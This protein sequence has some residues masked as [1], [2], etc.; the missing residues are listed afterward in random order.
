[1]LP[2]MTARA[3]AV[4]LAAGS[5]SRLGTDLPKAFLAIGGRSMLSIAA[6]AAASS[7]AITGLVITVPAGEESRAAGHLRELVVPASVIRGGATRQASVRAAL[8]V[9][10][11]DVE[12]VVVHDAAR[13]F[14]APS[15]FTAV[16]EAVVGGAI[17]AV[18]VVPVAD[19]VKRVRDE[20]VVETIDRGELALAQTPQ[21]FRVDALRAAH[22]RALSTGLEGTDDAMLLEGEAAVVAVPG[23]PSNFKVTTMFDLARAEAQ[24]ERGS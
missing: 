17:G 11:P 8:D 19:T 15:L 7:P 5:G 21:A 10:E 6:T 24:M 22:E 20:L 1:M 18:P 4:V 12:F 14:A 13:P 3:T 2:G 9:L 16:V 23:D